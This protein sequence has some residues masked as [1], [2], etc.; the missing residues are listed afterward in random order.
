RVRE[1]CTAHAITYAQAFG[2]GK[3]ED[4]MERELPM[5]GIVR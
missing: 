3:F 2:A 4:F 5:L 1:I